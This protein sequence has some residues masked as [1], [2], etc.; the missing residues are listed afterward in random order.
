MDQD[1]ALNNMTIGMFTEEENTIR[2]NFLKKYGAEVVLFNKLLGVHEA[3]L[4][5]TSG[6]T[7]NDDF[8]DW[9]IQILLSQTLPLMNNAMN[10]LACGYLRSS[11]IMIRVTSEAV[12]LSNYFKEFPEI[13][14]EYRSKNYRDFSHEHPVESMLKEVQEKG[15]I[16]IKDKIQAKNMHWH[17]KVFENTF[18]EASMFI[19]HNLDLLYNLTVDNQSTNP[20]TVNLI[21]GPHQYEDETLSMGIKRI[22][23][24]TLYSLLVLG[25]SFSIIPDNNEIKIVD[26]SNE[27]TKRG[28]NIE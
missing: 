19:H 4:K 12:I 17:R 27:L 25:V 15:T 22:F 21:M 8:P 18:E 14:K 20:D 13:E 7:R 10:L 16:F 5:S 2:Q 24:I 1:N 11:E 9:T 3:F 26:E 23:N 28:E 6:K